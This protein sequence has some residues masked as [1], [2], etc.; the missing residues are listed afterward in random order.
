M[1][2]EKIDIAL[3][4]NI[5][6]SRNN[7][8][9]TNDNYINN[10]FN[11]TE[12]YKKDF[13]KSQRKSKDNKYNISNTNINNNLDLNSNNDF[14]TKSNKEAFP[15]LNTNEKISNKLELTNNIN[16]DI[17]EKNK[18]N[19]N[20]NSHN[21]EI[22]KKSLSIREKAY[23][24]LTKSKVLNL[25][26]RIIFSRSTKKISSLISKEDILKSNELVINN[27]IKKLEQKINEYNKEI[28]APFSPSK[29][30]TIS[31]NLIMKE[32][33]DD[34][35][36]AILYEYITDENEKYYYF[37]YIQLLLLLQ[38]EEIDEIDLEKKGIN[39]LYKKLIKNKCINIKDY[40]YKLFIS[41]TIKIVK[42]NIEIIDKYNQ[43]FEELPD[44][45]KYDGEIKNIKFISFSYYIL[46]EANNHL[47]T[48]KNSI[49]VKNEIQN[50]IDSLKNK[51][52]KL[53]KK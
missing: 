15:L 26:E 51:I 12:K 41:K 10:I 42:I 3:G 17:N 6:T 19:V 34:F 18:L 25:C 40:L 24:I 2:G 50:Y 20:M 39:I 16:K 49:K 7:A 28:E 11:S 46:N 43:L 8:K 53:N 1:S 5:K 4:K 47:K 37:I 32:D 22:I 33:E 13:P 23:Y 48:I 35:K 36:N 30:S 27:K 31:L 21:K 44:L 29:I 52:K 14:I 45:I 38:G 9:N